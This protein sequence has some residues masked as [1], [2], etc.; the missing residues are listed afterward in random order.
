MEAYQVDRNWRHINIDKY[1]KYISIDRIWS[2][3][4]LIDI[5]ILFGEMEFG[6]L[7]IRILI[8]RYLAIW[9]N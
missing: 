7:S 4:T 3:S 9:V 6:Y 5:Q 2:L 8:N 1:P